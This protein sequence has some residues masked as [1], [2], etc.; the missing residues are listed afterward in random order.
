MTLLVDGRSNS[1]G[2]HFGTLWVSL[3]DLVGVLWALLGRP[4]ALYGAFL[5][6]WLVLAG[7]IWL[8]RA[9]WVALAGSIWLPWAPCLALAGSI[10]LP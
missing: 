2:A 6:T 5:A 9:P 10:W 3:G 1:L 8:P 4:G 7:S